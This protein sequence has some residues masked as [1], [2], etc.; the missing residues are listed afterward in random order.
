MII[1]RLKIK[2][3]QKNDERTHAKHAKIQFCKSSN[4]YSIKSIN[5]GYFKK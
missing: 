4:Y 2:I 5:L 1:I 3:F